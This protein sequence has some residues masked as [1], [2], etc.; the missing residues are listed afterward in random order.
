MITANGCDE[1]IYH[2][3]ESLDDLNTLTESSN[4]PQTG[5][6]MQ[7]RV[8]EDIFYDDPHSLPPMK[9]QH[10]FSSESLL[11]EQLSSPP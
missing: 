4:P 8:D 6:R 10:T 3:R 11:S 9:R 7:K 5:G 2:D 1:I